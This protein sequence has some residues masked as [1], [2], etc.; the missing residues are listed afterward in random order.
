MT[1]RDSRGISKLDSGLQ[2]ISRSLKTL[3]PDRCVLI[4]SANVQAIE[5]ESADQ[6]ELLSQTHPTASSSDLPAMMEAVNDFIVANRPSRCEVWIC[7]DVRKHDWDNGSGRWD[8]IRQSLREL[9]Q[10]IRFHLLA[11]TSPPAK[12]RSLRVT[13][14]RRIEGA[15]GSQLMLSF[16]IRNG[17][18]LSQPTSIPI[19]LELNGARSE[20]SVPISGSQSQQHNHAL[21][22]DA[23]QTRGWGRISVGPD[24]VPADNE[25][26]FV[27]DRP[28]ERKTIIVADSQASVQ[29]LQ[30]AAS[31]SSDADIVCS[32]Q[33]IT[34]D[35][36]T[37]TNLEEAALVI[38]Q[39]EIPA[40][41]DPAHQLLQLFVDRGGQLLFCPPA[42]VSDSSFAGVRWTDWQQHNQVG[43]TNWIGDQDLL[44]RTLGGE[45]LPVG[46]LT[47]SKTCNVSGDFVTLAQIDS[48]VPI[49]V[50]AM[51]DQRNVYFCT[52]TVAATDSSLADNGVVLYAVVHRLLAAGVESL[53]ATG[54]QTAGEVARFDSQVWQQLAG[55]PAALS[56]E[57]AYHAGVYSV[58]ERLLAINR[59]VGEDASTALES[60]EVAALF[61]GLDFNRMEVETGDRTA[62]VQEIWRLCLVLMMAALVAE[63]ALCIPGKLRAGSQK[64]AGASFA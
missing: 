60:E 26:F 14:A 62:L 5:L 29:P 16:N 20:F 28:I 47:F 11:F 7:S 42:V 24:A 27:Y 49:L 38:W 57:F 13:E 9:P 21:S 4:D 54:M 33:T 45:A 36:W 40:D 15:D 48:G 34:P 2:K 55:S 59:S 12:N 18:D 23:A 3:Q 8:A 64:S 44:G 39:A 6:L 17:D 41:T 10:S 50:R 53:G 63:A 37:G 46:E 22:I 19:Q 32:Q 61:E 51:T 1:V 58:D 30:F 25:F 35:Q 52:T 56:T 31:V 43:V